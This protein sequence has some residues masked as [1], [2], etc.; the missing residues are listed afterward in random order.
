M[1]R[2]SGLDASQSNPPS[3]NTAP[4]Y[5]A[6]HDVT[7]LRARAH[8]L[9]R[10]LAERHGIEECIAALPH[11]GMGFLV[12]LPINSVVPVA[13]DNNDAI[14]Q[15]YRQWLWWLLLSLSEAAVH[16]DRIAT[17]PDGVRL[18]RLILEQR[19][20]EALSLVGEP[21]W[22]ALGYEFLSNPGVSDD[23]LAELLELMGHCRAIRR[24]A[25]DDG[26]LALWE[27]EARY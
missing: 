15:L 11:H 12:D 16:P 3:G 21:D 19:D 6:S 5:P 7:N 4:N 20:H 14:D 13:A 9:A 17:V 23:T 18:K 27:S 2:A 8:T 24:L 22:K 10:R 26:G 1:P 25:G